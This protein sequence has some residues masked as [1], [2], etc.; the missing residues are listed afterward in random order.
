MDNRQLREFRDFEE[1]TDAFNDMSEDLELLKV[2]TDNLTQ[3]T[4]EGKRAITPKQHGR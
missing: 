1:I 4:L 3:L 2:R